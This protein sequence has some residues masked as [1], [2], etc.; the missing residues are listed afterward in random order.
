MPSELQNICCHESYAWVMPFV[1]PR[2]H[3][4]CPSSGSFRF[5]VVT[6][7][8]GLEMSVWKE[9]RTSSF[10]VAGAERVGTYE[11]VTPLSYHNGYYYLQSPLRNISVVV[12]HI[13]YLIVYP[14]VK[15]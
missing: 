6:S 9:A 14:N 10:L 1:D 13:I 11:K 7:L 2:L 15:I 5:I 4:W 12:I 3:Q 8:K